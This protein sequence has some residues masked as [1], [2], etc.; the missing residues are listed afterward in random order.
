MSYT[1]IFDITKTSWT[2]SLS[3]LPLIPLLAGSIMTGMNIS[4]MWRGLPVYSWSARPDKPFRVFPYMLLAIG[5]GSAY[6]TYQHSYV[7]YTD[8]RSAYEAGKCEITEGKVENLQRNFKKG[9]SPVSF[10]I[11]HKQFAFRGGRDTPAFQQT[12]SSGGPVREGQQLRIASCDGAIVK[13]EIMD[14][15]EPDKQRADDNKSPHSE[16]NPKNTVS[17]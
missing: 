7:A 14:Y 10:D 5:M 16:L 3:L 15:A 2:D 4:R 12:T 1:L 9:E 8:L 17:Q 6:L 11:G 13:L